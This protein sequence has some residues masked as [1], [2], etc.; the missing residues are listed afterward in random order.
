M[1]RKEVRYAQLV[2]RD[3]ILNEL[4]AYA[5]PIEI[6]NDKELNWVVKKRF[7]IDAK[8]LWKSGMDVV[9]Y[10]IVPEPIFRLHGEKV[11]KLKE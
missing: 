9:G 1:S 3:H 5:Q 10:V 11:K 7:P 2:Y 6:H 4:R 8:D